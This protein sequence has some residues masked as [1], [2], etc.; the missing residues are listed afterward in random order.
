M[1]SILYVKSS[2]LGAQSATN[3]VVD[4]LHAHWQQ[5]H[6][7]ANHLVRNLGAEPL[8]HLDQNTLGALRS[9]T[10]DA[11]A[12]ALAGQKALQELLDADTLVLAAPMY[13]F[14]IP[15]ALKAWLDHVIH[16]GKTFQYTA[17]GPEG[18]LKG[19]KAILVL[20]TGGAYSEG[21]AKSMDFVEPYLRTVLGFLGI[22]DVTAVRAESLAMGEA[23]ALSKAKALETVRAL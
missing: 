18:L 14:G 15:S 1:K 4:A 22:T 16:P 7:G 9:E 20:A 11:Q 17:N 8:P 23:G 5:K 2:L 13:N 3:S 19:K 12:G 6:A 10:N 21:P